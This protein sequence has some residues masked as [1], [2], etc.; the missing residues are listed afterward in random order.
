[1]TPSLAGKKGLVIGIANEH[2]IAWGA[3]QAFRAAGA[4]LAVTW[5]N[6][7]ARPYVEPLA[8]QLD[9]SIQLPLDVEQEGAME[10]VFAAITAQWG[11]LDFVLHSIAF[12]RKEDLHG[13]VVDTSRAGF[14]QA[15]D[16]SCHS[17]VRAARLA[18][19]LMKQGGCLLTMSY[20][21]AE[22]VVANYG[23][24]GPVKAALESS[25]RYLAT[26]LGPQGIRVSAV[27]P[28][29]LATRAASGIADFQHLLNDAATRAPLRRLTTIEEVGALCAFLVSDA[30]ASITGDTLYVDAGYHILG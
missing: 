13:R 6:D 2:S 8:Q 27:S 23:L 9:A 17:F 30:A 22:E 14:A 29:P 19:P 26:E 18:E 24:M 7:K 12:A 15:M 21:G 4:E 16:V 10:A 28:G 5:L 1:M 20:L 11:K 25:V 3:A